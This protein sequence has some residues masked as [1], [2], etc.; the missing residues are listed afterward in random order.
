[1]SY[2]NPGDIQLADPGAF[3]NAFNSVIEPYK[4]KLEEKAAEKKKLL[5]KYDAANAKLTASM[6]YPSWVEKYGSTKAAA[7]KQM[8]EED[9]IKNNRFAGASLSDQQAMLDEIQTN[10]VQGV[11]TLDAAIALD[12]REVLPS[13]L[14]SWTST[15]KEFMDFLASKPNDNNNITIERQNGELGFSYIFD[16]QKRFISQSK[17]PKGAIDYKGRGAINQEIQSTIG[18]G[19]QN[20][21]KK[22]AE[23]VDLVGSEQYLESTAA[24]IYASIKND[25]AKLETI[26]ESWQIDFN[27]KEEGT[28]DI[29][30]ADAMADPELRKIADKAITSYIASRVEDDS[31]ELTRLKG[32]EREKQ[33]KAIEKQ[34]E[35]YAAVIEEEAKNEKQA[36][37][38]KSNLNRFLVTS[39]KLGFAFNDDGTVKNPNH[40]I[41]FNNATL[42]KVELF[43]N[44]NCY[45]LVKPYE[46]EDGN[47]IGG[48]FKLLG[49]SKTIDISDGD[50]FDQLTYKFILG[51]GMGSASTVK[52][53]IMKVSKEGI[54]DMGEFEPNLE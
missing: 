12:L 20:I 22:F 53:D 14:N 10:I 43:A 1:M 19:V 41:I 51:K 23:A 48:K 27:G 24:S 50:T 33:E 38:Y 11:K 45:E 29:S 52:E 54:V 28:G 7:I 30:Y 40:S 17:M 21:D 25:P 47:I 2:R 4:A 16:G 9:Y 36:K 32:K 8:V 6:D 15:N 3:M 37:K 13:H 46:D 39:R 49:T 5:E 26:F 42:P 18:L 44:E 35:K 34:Q 31:K